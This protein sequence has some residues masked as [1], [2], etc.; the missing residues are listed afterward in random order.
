[1]FKMLQTYGI[2]D[3]LVT[4]IKNMCKNSQAEVLLLDDETRS[5]GIQAVVLKGDTLAL[6]LFVIVLK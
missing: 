6:Y 4:A 2:P 5:F 3:I 1:M